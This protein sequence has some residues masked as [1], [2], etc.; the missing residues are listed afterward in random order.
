MKEMA[1]IRAPGG[2]AVDQQTYEGLGGQNRKA[3]EG[4]IWEE[5]T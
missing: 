3:T 1:F 4:N 5:I 2:P